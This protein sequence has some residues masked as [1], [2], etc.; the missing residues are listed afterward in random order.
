M[1]KLRKASSMFVREA[2]VNTL[3]SQIERYGLKDHLSITV[4]PDG[5]GD[6]TYPELRHIYIQYQLIENLI[7]F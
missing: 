2:L 6:S 5:E 1:K 3:A 7:Q 4:E